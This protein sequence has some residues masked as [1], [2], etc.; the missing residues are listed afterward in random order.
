MLLAGRRR[1]PARLGVEGMIGAVGMARDR[2]APKGTVLV[3]G[4]YWTAETD[5]TIDPGTPVEVTGVEG[6]RLRVR[7]REP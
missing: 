3:H 6:L 5:G 1:G 7:R 4:E 2:L